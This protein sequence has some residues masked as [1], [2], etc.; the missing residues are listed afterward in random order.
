MTKPY[1]NEKQRI[2]IHSNTL[3]GDA[4]IL[5]LRIMQFL[6]ELYRILRIKKIITF[7]Y[8]KN[9]FKAANR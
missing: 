5:R 4:L 7:L 1:F 3:T 9:I 8:D 2:I 6:R